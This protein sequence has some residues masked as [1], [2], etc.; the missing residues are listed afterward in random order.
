MKLDS[1]GIQAY[2]A[3]SC[4]ETHLSGESGRNQQI[5]MESEIEIK[6]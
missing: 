3:I 1:N 6:T 2:E 5:L 4:I